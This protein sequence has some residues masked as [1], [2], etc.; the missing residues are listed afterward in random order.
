MR[1]R[2]NADGSFVLYAIGE[3]GVDD[4]GDP[5]PVDG[6][7][8]RFY[9]GKDLVWPKPASAEEIKTFISKTRPGS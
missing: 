6:K 4:G 3:N 1:Y 5:T 2:L 7:L 9:N 8:L